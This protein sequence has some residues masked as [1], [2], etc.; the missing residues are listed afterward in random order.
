[1]EHYTIILDNHGVLE[2]PITHAQ[3][4][5]RHLP[6]CTA[7]GDAGVGAADMAVLDSEMHWSPAFSS[8]VHRCCHPV[9]P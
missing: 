5:A 4:Q 7:V 2:L 3:K 1:M 6:G 9:E 8:D